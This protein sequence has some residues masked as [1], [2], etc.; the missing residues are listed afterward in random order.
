VPE[1][2][3]HGKIVGRTIATVLLIAL[4]CLV[5]SVLLGQNIAGGSGVQVLP[6]QAAVRP[7]T[8][9]GFYAP[10]TQVSSSPRSDVCVSLQAAAGD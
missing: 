3:S 6:D 1:S 5:P 2:R 7:P 9:S 8:N 10:A 4:F